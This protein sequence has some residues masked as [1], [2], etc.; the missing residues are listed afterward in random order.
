MILVRFEI[1]SERIS[2]MRR[3]PKHEAIGTVIVARCSVVGFAMVRALEKGDES[4]C[5]RG[6]FLGQFLAPDGGGK[7]ASN[8]GR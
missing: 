7:G 3:H 2:T 6:G 8:F 5:F 1:G 4:G